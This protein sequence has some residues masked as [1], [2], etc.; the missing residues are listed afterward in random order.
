MVVFTE[1]ETL[2]SAAA[3]T[4]TTQPTGATADSKGPTQALLQR[5]A[6]LDLKLQTEVA[7]YAELE[8]ALRREQDNHKEAI[9]SLSLQQQKIKDS[10]RGRA[11]LM[12]DFTRVENQL[13]LQINETEQVQLKYES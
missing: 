13:R 5:C 1:A 4:S 9:E 11:K 8:T 2:F 10:R 3:V 6:G 7:R 12:E